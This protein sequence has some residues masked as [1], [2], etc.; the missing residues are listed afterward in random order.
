MNRFI[1]SIVLASVAWTAVA[2]ADTPARPNI[3]FILSDDFGLDG[4]GC[5]GSDRFKDKTPNLDSLAK[6]GIRFTHCYATPL[7]GPSRC[8]INTGR[9]AFRTGGLTN[10]MARLPSFKDE[11]SL[12]R[13]LKQA[14][15]ATGMA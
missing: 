3:L 13:T 4:V 15:Y 7:C 8:A 2:H 10:R 14:G 12:A 9:Y 1:Q 6:S 5:Y 11:P